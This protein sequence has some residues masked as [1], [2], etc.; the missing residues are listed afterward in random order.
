MIFVKWSIQYLFIPLLII[1][2][3]Y[4]IH[5]GKNNLS[6]KQSMEY[7]GHRQIDTATME[8]NMEIP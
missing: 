2:W 5:E 3:V 7:N 8:K 1:I 4:L 6:A